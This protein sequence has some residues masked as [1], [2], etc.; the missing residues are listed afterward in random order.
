MS[1][2]SAMKRLGLSDDDVEAEL[3]QLASEAAAASPVALTAVDELSE[4]EDSQ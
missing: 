3:E 1:Q 4:K 2:Y